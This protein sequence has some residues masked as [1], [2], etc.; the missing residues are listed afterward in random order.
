MSGLS[1]ALMNECNVNTSEL[2]SGSPSVGSSQRQQILKRRNS[3]SKTVSINSNVDPSSYSHGG[4]SVGGGRER[5]ISISSTPPFGQSPGMPSAPI[6]INA[7]PPFAVAPLTMRYL[8]DKESPNFQVC[9]NRKMRPNLYSSLKFVHYYSKECFYHL[10]VWKDFQYHHFR[11]YRCGKK[12]I[13]L[14]L[15]SQLL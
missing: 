9:I 6:T 14:L 3:S 7:T 2:H 13:H 4:S 8:N 15:I 12:I 5:G 10:Q 1:L 11:S